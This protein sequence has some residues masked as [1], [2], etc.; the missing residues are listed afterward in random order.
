M[1]STLIRRRAQQ[2]K[3]LAHN[4]RPAV[5]SRAWVPT[6]KREIPFVPE[7]K[8]WDKGNPCLCAHGNVAH[9]NAKH[10]HLQGPCKVPGCGC[11][12]FR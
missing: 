11:K 6:G 1:N 4:Y 5:T 3:A 9:M 8:W 2:K 7:V 10:P 12:G